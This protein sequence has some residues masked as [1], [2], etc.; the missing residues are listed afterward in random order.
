MEK[1]SNAV[2]GSLEWIAQQRAIC[3]AATPGPWVSNEPYSPMVTAENPYGKGLMHIADIRGWGHL[4]GKGACA[5]T[6]EK[7]SEIQAAN[8][9]FIVSAKAGYRATLDIL[10]EKTKLL[11]RV[12]PE[13]TPAW[14]AYN[15][16]TVMTPKDAAMRIREHMRHH[17]ISEPQS[18]GISTALLMGADSL[19]REAEKDATIARLT[20]ERD[21][22]VSVLDRIDYRLKNLLSTLATRQPAGM[23]EARSGEERADAAVQAAVHRCWMVHKAGE[24]GYP[25]PRIVAG[26]CFGYGGADDEPMCE[27]CEACGLCVDN[28]FA[29]TGPCAEN[30]PTGDTRE[31][32]K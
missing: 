11:N 21:A 2:I 12:L 26:R 32:S 29:H 5:L 25:E 23:R 31:E 22:A 9:E 10:E 6:D 3:D 19:E 13:G 20:V 1:Q 4:T 28:T 8:S 17:G 16:P 24:A 18:I 7:A 30:A 14:M 27:R 15:A